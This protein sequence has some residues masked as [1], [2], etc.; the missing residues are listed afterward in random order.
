[1]KSRVDTC[2]SNLFIYLEKEYIRRN[3]DF[4]R[5]VPVVVII[6]LLLLAFIGRIKLVLIDDII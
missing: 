5:F 4:Q 1:M 2:D 3:N 6:I